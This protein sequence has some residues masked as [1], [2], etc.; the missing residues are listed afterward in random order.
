MAQSCRHAIDGIP[1]R[2]R[3]RPG[4]ATRP[5]RASCRSGVSYVPRRTARSRPCWSE[6]PS[7][8][9]AVAKQRVSGRPALP[10]V[11]ASAQP[12]DSDRP[13]RPDCHPRRGGVAWPGS[14]MSS[15]TATSD[16]PAP[17][18]S[19]GWRMHRSRAKSRS[20]LDSRVTHVRRFRSLVARCC[21]VWPR[22]PL[23]LGQMGSHRQSGRRARRDVLYVVRVG[24]GQRKPG[25]VHSSMAPM[26][27]RKLPNRE[28]FG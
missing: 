28:I 27:V 7:S 21:Q 3:S 25:G 8:L 2:D 9:P 10:G 24:D 22:R 16:P 13:N 18:T 15:T 1:Q 6:R 14:K 20:R 11:A 4:L 17:A 5:W 19:L 12:A 26:P 23:I